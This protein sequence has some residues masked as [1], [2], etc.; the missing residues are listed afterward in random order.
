MHHLRCLSE[1]ALA[2]KDTV[3][4]LRLG[5]ESDSIENSLTS[6]NKKLDILH[7]EVNHD[8]ESV[9]NS[10]RKH[11]ST[12]TSYQW[13]IAFLVFVSALILYWAY[14]RSQRNAHRYDAIISELKKENKDQ[15]INLKTLQ[16]NIDR[17]KI[18]D[19]DLKEFINSHNNMMREVIEEC[20]HMPHGPLAKAIRKIIKYQDENSGIWS[21]LYSYL[22]MEYNNIMSETKKHY[23]QL[24]E[25]DLLMIALTCM[26]YSCAQIA[27][28]LDYSSS[29][30]ISTIRKRIATKM[31]LN[32]LLG[33][34]I[35]Q[36]KSED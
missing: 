7:A 34:Y 27:I 11:N 6:N 4:S 25:K 19:E 21:K 15:S 1:L 35:K 18:K 32:C 17:L 29:S 8:K 14:R 3:T 26:G 2:K 20:Y 36:S 31:G 33:E 13:L 30:G 12:V 23:P 5:S 10:Q 28:V 16:N 22:D 9:Q 24:D